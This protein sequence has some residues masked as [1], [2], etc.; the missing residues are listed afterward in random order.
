MQFS[1]GY[2]CGGHGRGDYLE[3][4]DFEYR[5]GTWRDKVSGVKSKEVV[6]AVV[7]GGVDEIRCSRKDVYSEMRRS[8]RMKPRETITVITEERNQSSRLWR[9]RQKGEG[10]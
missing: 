1:Y 5:R 6:M 8:L 4:V 7:D 2:A 10:K 3:L 9:N